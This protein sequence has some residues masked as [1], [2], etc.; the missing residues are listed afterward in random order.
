[1]TA[2]NGSSFR[3][4]RLI[5]GCIAAVLPVTALFASSAGAMK[6]PLTP[7]NYTAL[8]DSLA[9]GYTADKFNKTAPAHEPSNFEEGYANFLTKKLA[10]GEKAS[11]NA[12]SLL[13]LG[14][15]GEVTDGLIGENPSLGGGQE[16]NGKSDSSPCAYHKA[17]LQLHFNIGTASQLETAIGIVTTPEA[18]GA[19]K[20]VTLN[21]GSNDELAVVGACSTEAYL[22]AHGFGG[23]F[24]CLIREAG[25]EGHYYSGG[26]FHHIIANI[27]DVVGVLRA[28]G[29]TGKVAILGFYNPQAFILPGSDL[30]QKKLNE[31]AECAIETKAHTCTVEPRAKEALTLPGEEKFGPNVVYANPFPRFNPQKSK[32]EHRRVE[33]LTEECNPN[34]QKFQ[35]GNDP[36]CEG[37]VHPTV[38][39]YKALATILFKAINKP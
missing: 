4:G 34:V 22:I 36:G 3:R 32:Q 30:L 12:L 27:G 33:R 19:T 17:G 28:F 5:G 7:T 2:R 9:F 18:F 8:G 25:P 15:P 35:T 31:V 39:G 38:A 20:M 6:T 23:V 10:K 21:I 11:G 16:A 37:D 14:C 26:L 1:M 13:N 24:E 29:Y